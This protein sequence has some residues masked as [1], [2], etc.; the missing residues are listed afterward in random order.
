MTLQK[1]LRSAHITTTNPGGIV[2]MRESGTWNGKIKLVETGV[3]IQSTKAPAAIEFA[4]A[5]IK[6]LNSR[7]FDAKRQTD[8]P[9][10]E[11]TTEPVIWVNVEPRPKGP[12]G[13]YKLQSERD[14]KAKK[15]TSTTR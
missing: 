15:D 5:L 8:P 4:D 13:E 2:E 11:K 1:H 10:D 7:G 9:F 14:T 6:Q 12:Q 3:V